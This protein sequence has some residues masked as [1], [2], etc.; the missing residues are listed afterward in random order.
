[1]KRALIVAFSVGA[2]VGFMAA[3]GRNAA[4][5]SRLQKE[6]ARV[7]EQSLTWAELAEDYEKDCHELQRQLEAQ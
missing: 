2:L 5:V 1:M 6:I 4:A 7:R 3:D